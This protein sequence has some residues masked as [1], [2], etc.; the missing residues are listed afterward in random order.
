MSTQAGRLPR[1]TWRLRLVVCSALLVAA[2]FL[3]RPGLITADTKLDLAVNP[4]GFLHRALHLWDPLGAFGQVQN[5][6]YGYLFPMGPFFAVA[7]LAGMP[8]WVAQR[9]WLSALLVTAFLGVVRLSRL[10][11][12]RSPWV[13]LLT[14]LAYALSPRMITTLGP[15]SIEALPSAMAPWVLIPLI[16]GSLRGSAARAGARSAVAVGLIGGVNAV[17]AAAALPLGAAWLLTRTYSRRLGQLWVSWVGFV[18]LATLWWLVPLFV[19]GKFSP[20]FLNFIENASVT[21]FPTTVVDSLRGA[22]HWVP[23]VSP[24]WSAGGRL[25]TTGWIVLDTVLLAALG[26]AGIARRDNPHRLFL[27]TGLLSGLLLVTF[28]HVGAVHGWFA[29]TQNSLLDGALS[30][31]RNVHKFD[32]VIR[33]PLLLGMAHLLDVAARR[34]RSPQL[35][36]RVPARIALA[37]A[38]LMVAGVGSPLWLGRLSPPAAFP[39]LPSY[40]QQTADWLAGHAEDGRALLLPASKFGEYTWGRSHDEALQPLARSPWAVRDGIPL[41]PPQ[42][43]AMLDAVQQRLADGRGSAGLAPYLRMSGVDYLVVRNDLDL[44]WTR[45][46]DPVLVHQALAA[47]PGMRRVAE[48]GPQTGGDPVVSD[49]AQV[50]F[51]ADWGVRER[52]P[53]IEI[54]AVDAPTLTPLP[55]S[56]AVG[57]DVRVEAASTSD[58]PV[59]EG[60]PAAILAAFDAGVVSGPVLLSEDQP[61]DWPFSRFVLTDARRRQQAAFGSVDDNRSATLTRDEPRG[62][63]RSRDYTED[64]RHETAAVLDGARAITASASG[65]DAGGL[66]GTDL[67]A[68]PYAAFDGDPATAWRPPEGIDATGQW[69]EIAFDQP[70]DTG[71]VEITLPRRPD[72]APSWSEV[73]RLRLSTDRSAVTVDVPAGARTVHAS[74]AGQASR[75]RVEIEAVGQRGD[76]PGVPGIAEVTVP[77]VHVRR[78]LELPAAQLQPDT[79]M[80]TRGPGDRDGCVL[81]GASQ[82]CD[83]ELMRAGEEGPSLDRIIDLPDSGRYDARLTARSRPGAALE[84]LLWGSARIKVAASSRSLATAKAAPMTALDGDPGTGWVAGRYDPRPRLTVTFD[85]VVSVDSMELRVYSG[86]AA[87]RP[88]TVRVRAAGG[89]RAVTLDARGNGH[90]RRLTGRVFTLDL[91]PRA[92]GVSMSTRDGSSARLPVGVSELR[93]SSGSTVMTP[94]EPVRDQRVLVPCEAGP[95]LDLNGTVVRTSAKVSRRDL[96]LGRPVPLELC[97]QDVRLDRGVNKVRLDASRALELTSAVFDSTAA[98]DEPVTSEPPDAVKVAVPPGRWG[99]VSR[100]V[101][102]DAN[103]R[104]S[105]LTV[106]ENSNPGWQARSGSRRLEPVVV[107]GWQQGWILPIGGPASVRLRYAPDASYRTAMPIGLVAFLL[108]LLVAFWPRAAVFVLPHGHVDLPTRTA[109]PHPLVTAV[110]GV[111]ALGFIGGWPGAAIGTALAVAAAAARRRLGGWRVERGLTALI[112][113]ALATAGVVYGLRPWGSGALA[114]FAGALRWPQLAAL[115]SLGA[116]VAALA[117]EPAARPI[118]QVLG[119]LRNRL[120]GDS[121]QR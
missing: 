5:Q 104:L 19:L 91:S 61:K 92:P 58:V 36:R 55:G 39:A 93:L 94:P 51:L 20:P 102:V 8:A 68:L 108:V 81:I 75:L 89:T 33:L 62:A 42:T 56:D 49:T 114:E 50:R 88:G 11:G 74:L 66:L 98:T 63:V 46:V 77:G 6:S 3:Q 34:A 40:W 54:F 14:G 107:N 96:F 10:L 121:S 45:A 60:G 31:L 2:A 82:R 78:W 115:V 18:T 53:A 37:M 12:V 38:A 21:T 43:I 67:S 95:V 101:A 24:D 1:A 120:R 41:T 99:S 90:F 59:L 106:G 70:A 28:G 52:Y 97:A 30:P 44:G 32:P 65:S 84:H 47:S 100:T 17:A 26:L 73:R 116:T 9:L 71:D 118:R 57:G 27:L 16:S 72:G 87:A 7:H 13:R 76:R 4:V 85:R 103:E 15:I 105:L 111:V 48:F 80:V 69:V 29:G 25:L 79:V 64:D 109:R 83:P 113:A 22:S 86:L 110:A 112:L 23:Y 35:P 117:A 119:G